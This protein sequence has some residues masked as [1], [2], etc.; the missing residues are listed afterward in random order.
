MSDEVY[1]SW[2]DVDVDK[3]VIKPASKK[4]AKNKP[5]YSSILSSNI[6]NTFNQNS[7]NKSELSPTNDDFDKGISINSNINNES[8]PKSSSSTS[9]FKVLQRITPNSCNDSN[10][11][12]QD[13][14]PFIN[15]P[16]ITLEENSS[17][18]I[19][20]V[21]TMKILN[22][23][24]QKNSSSTKDNL[25]DED[26]IQRRLKKSFEEKQAE[27]AKARLRIFGE[28]STNDDIV[29]NNLTNSIDSFNLQDKMKKSINLQE[30][31]KE[32]NPNHSAIIRQPKAPDGTR[33][34]S[35]H[36]K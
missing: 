2:E 15:Q 11:D 32:N 35:R 7:D 25:D 12:N 36:K 1:D 9:T 26:E 18:R 14:F 27:Y 17:T 20:L 29:L 28:E 21:K 31:V 33:G 23:P 3:I 4:N 13:D 19:P 16:K 8:S 34:F 30:L 10:F 6:I 24:N 5:T 22:R